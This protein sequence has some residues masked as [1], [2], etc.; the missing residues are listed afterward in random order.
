MVF[1]ADRDAGGVDLCIAR[2]GEESAFFVRAPGGGD[3]A[4][5]GVGGKK[6][7]IA[8]AASGEHDGVTGVRGDFTGDQIAN[9]DALGM[10]IDSDEIEHFG[11]GK[12]LDR[13][14]SDLAAEGLVSAK[15][16]LLAGLAARVK[17]A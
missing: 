3:V 4:P 14:E 5:F 16:Q 9:D 10:A 7:D 13:T 2:V 15:E 6:E 12:H 8:I 11:T 1:A 17:G